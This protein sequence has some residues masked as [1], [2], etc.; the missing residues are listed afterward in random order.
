MLKNLLR[1]RE[2]TTRNE[3]PAQED[4]PECENDGLKSGY[5]MHAPHSDRLLS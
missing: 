3:V 4:A 1:L 5:G 2:V